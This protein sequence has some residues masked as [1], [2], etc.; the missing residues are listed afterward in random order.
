[1]VA[2]AAHGI[3]AMGGAGRA[4]LDA[5]ASDRHN[6]GPTPSTRTD[7]V[8]SMRAAARRLEK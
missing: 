2:G 4:G 5:K 1:M 7:V 6:G 3:I 8:G